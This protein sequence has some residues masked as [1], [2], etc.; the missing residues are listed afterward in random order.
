[1]HKYTYQLLRASSTIEKRSVKVKVPYIPFTFVN[2]VFTFVTLAKLL[3]NLSVYL[4]YLLIFF[5]LNLKKNSIL[6][7]LFSYYYNYTCMHL[8]YIGIKRF[9]F[10]N[11]IKNCHNIL[12][13][14]PV[15]FFIT[16][17]YHVILVIN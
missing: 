9:M 1:M 5:L 15:F 14:I 3:L 16:H 17:V 10:Y 2:L 7:N 4:T 6:D 13:I 11:Q 8:L 12:V